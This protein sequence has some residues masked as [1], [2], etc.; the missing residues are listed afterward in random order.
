MDWAAQILGLD[1][2]FYNAAEGG[3]RGGGVMQVCFLFHLFITIY[4]CHS[5][6]KQVTLR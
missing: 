2:S 4:M 5:R 1:K 3:G 6:P